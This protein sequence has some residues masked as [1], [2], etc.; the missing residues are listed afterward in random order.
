VIVHNFI[1]EDGE[2]KSKSKSDW[3]A[4]IKGLRAVLC[5]LIVLKGTV[6]DCFKLITL[7]ALGNVSVVITDHLVEEG[8]GF[9]SGGSL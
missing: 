9:I 7:S 4:S 3:V 1:V 8:F 5:K 6:F 2:V